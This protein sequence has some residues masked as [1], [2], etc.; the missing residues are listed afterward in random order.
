MKYDVSE[1][2]YS[3]SLKYN[4]LIFLL[5][6]SS[7][8]AGTW[9]STSSSTTYTYTDYDDLL[10]QLQVVL[11][12]YIIIASDWNAFLTSFANLSKNYEFKKNTYERFLN[13]WR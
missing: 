3:E 11:A 12:D 10:N 5:N 7:Y 2:L 13:G 6:R 9:T 8:G 4:D 1:S